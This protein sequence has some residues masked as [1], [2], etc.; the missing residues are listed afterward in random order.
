LDTLAPEARLKEGGVRLSTTSSED[1]I[2]AV[3]YIY[4][5]KDFSAAAYAWNPWQRPTYSLV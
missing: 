5:L 4:V 1:M 3:I 2:E